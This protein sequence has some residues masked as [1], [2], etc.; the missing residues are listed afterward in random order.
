M[1]SAVIMRTFF[2][3]MFLLTMIPTFY[4]IAHALTNGSSEDVKNLNPGIYG[5]PS[6]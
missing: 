1:N 5:S 2:I 4:L 6:H 3:V